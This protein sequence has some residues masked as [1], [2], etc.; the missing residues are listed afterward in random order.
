[1]PRS[2]TIRVTVSREVVKGPSR[3]LRF[4]KRQ[5]PMNTF[6]QRVLILFGVLYLLTGIAKYLGWWG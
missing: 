3:V 1:M 6:F 5:I 2:L 4:Y